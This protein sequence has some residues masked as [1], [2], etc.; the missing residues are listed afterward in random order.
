MAHEENGTGI[1]TKLPGIS[2]R[3]ANGLG[4]VPR[5]LL[6]GGLGDQA[7]VYGHEHTTSRNECLRLGAHLFLAALRPPATVYPNDHRTVRS[8]SGRGIDVEGLAFVDR[9]RIWNIPPHSGVSR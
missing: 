8:T 2:I 7:I 1:T 4:H 5:H 9:L 3:P 6:Q